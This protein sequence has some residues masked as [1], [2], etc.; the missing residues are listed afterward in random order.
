MITHEVADLIPPAQ[1]PVMR[2]SS[3]VGRFCRRSSDHGRTALRSR[4]MQHS[5]G[6]H[7][8]LGPTMISD[9]S[10]SHFSRATGRGMSLTDGSY[11]YTPPDTLSIIVGQ[12]L[13]RLTR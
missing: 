7:D 3:V 1:N 8:H 5:S 6:Q 12:S 2:R 11:H 4:E 13:A 9:P 10:C